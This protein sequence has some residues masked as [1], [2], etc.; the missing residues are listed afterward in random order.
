MAEQWLLFEE[1]RITLRAFKRK[2][3]I[4][5]NDAYPF[6]QNKSIEDITHQD[7]IK[8]IKER[9]AK[10]IHLEKDNDNPPDGIQTANKLYNHLNTIF[11]YAITLGFAERNPFQIICKTK[12][13]FN[14][15]VCKVA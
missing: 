9:L 1:D 6:L 12:K 4:I 14:L 10:K 15:M 11:K 8:V 2:K 7:I 3:A 13:I 5:E